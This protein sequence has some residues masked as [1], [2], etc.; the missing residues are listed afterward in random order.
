MQ[1]PIFWTTYGNLLENI[2]GKDREAYSVA[3]FAI[4]IVFDTLFI[5]LAEIL[6]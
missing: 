1:R 3:V 6:G 2:P 4:Y 5:R